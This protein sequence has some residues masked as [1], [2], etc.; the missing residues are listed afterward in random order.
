MSVTVSNGQCQ[1]F[2]GFRCTLHPPTQC[3]TF[4]PSPAQTVTPKSSNR[5]RG[6]SEFSENSD[7]YSA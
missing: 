5:N 1:I 7:G 2:N 3:P 4:T 6:Y